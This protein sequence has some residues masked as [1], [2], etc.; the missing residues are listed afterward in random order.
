VLEN[1]E[2]FF[3]NIQ[4]IA[5]SARH[6]VIIYQI[7]AFVIHLCCNFT[8]LLNNFCWWG[9]KVWF[10]PS[11]AGYPRY[12]TD[13]HIAY[14]QGSPQG[15]AELRTLSN[16]WRLFFEKRLFSGKCLPF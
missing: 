2:L 10:C 15:N 4:K 16:K 8:L 1:M 3:I 6:S 5:E 13:T 9:W 14:A 12:A 7:S 11:G